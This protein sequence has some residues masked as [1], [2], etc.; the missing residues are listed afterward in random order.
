MR[1]ILVLAVFA[2][3]AVQMNAQHLRPDSVLQ[4]NSTQ[5]DSAADPQRTPDK[6]GRLLARSKDKE[7][8][9]IVVRTKAGDVE[10]HE[11][12]DDV[13]LIRSGKGILR[14]GFDLSGAKLSGVK[15]AREWLGGSIADKRERV[16][17]AGDFLVIPA[18]L[19][20]Q[21][22]PAPG[23]TL[24]YFVVKVRNVEKK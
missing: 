1:R 5:L 2:C 22:I 8:Y 9:L 18:M 7:S 13:T 12:F 15:P 14:T 17:K 23:D 3:L 10:M 16:I 19:A 6:P 11:Q 20:H 21:Y 24:I 4:F